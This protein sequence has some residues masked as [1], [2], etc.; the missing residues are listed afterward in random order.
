MKKSVEEV[1]KNIDFKN[2]SHSDYVIMYDLL[3]LDNP[4]LQSDVEST[5]LRFKEMWGVDISERQIRAVQEP[6]IDTDIQD[7]NLYYP[8]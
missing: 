3:L 8:R 5:V 2:L 6:T 1:K 4:E 7:L